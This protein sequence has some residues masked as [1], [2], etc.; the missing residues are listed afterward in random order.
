MILIQKKAKKIKAIYVSFYSFLI[1]EIILM[2]F[3]WWVN[4]S[5][6]LAILFVDMIP[7]MYTMNKLH[8]I[9]GNCIYIYI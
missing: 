6:T 4:P 5:A 8:I 9:K 7:K 2:D 3:W 1:T